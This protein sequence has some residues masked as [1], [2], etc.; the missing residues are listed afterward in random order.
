MIR[1][2]TLERSVNVE[3]YVDPIEIYEDLNGLEQIEFA[4]H[5]LEDLYWNDKLMAI[6]DALTDEEKRKLYEEL[7]NKI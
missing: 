4:K 5:I 6:M 1:E 2:V 3:V 7:T